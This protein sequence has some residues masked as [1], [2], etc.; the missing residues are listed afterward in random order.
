V[1]RKH[2][3]CIAG[4][5]MLTEYG[6]CI[7][8]TQ[9]P[10][11][12]TS[13]QH[14][15]YVYIHKSTSLDTIKNLLPEPRSALVS[16]SCDM[17]CYESFFSYKLYLH[18]TEQET[19]MHMIENNVKFDWSAMFWAGSSIVFYRQTCLFWKFLIGVRYGSIFSR[20]RGWAIFPEKFFNS[21]RKNCY[22][23]LRNYFARLTPPSNY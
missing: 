15:Q 9:L 11:N 17:L 4:E 21:A 8:H 1:I 12:A 22:A 13:H 18:P 7:N 16:W 10:L 3:E 5:E 19:C 23:N 2:G 14:C 6:R 20:R